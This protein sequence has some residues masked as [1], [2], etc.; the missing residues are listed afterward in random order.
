MKNLF[1]I[2]LVFSI[3]VSCSENSIEH[4]LDDD[5]KIK[6]YFNYTEQYERNYSVKIYNSNDSI[7][8]EGTSII[9]YLDKRLINSKEYFAFTNKLNFNNSHEYFNVMHRFDE[10]YLKLFVDT[11]DSYKLIP[12]SLSETLVLNFVPEL[13]LLKFPIQ[14][15][16][17]W[18]T[19][20][21]DVVIGTFSINIVRFDASYVS[22]ESIQV[23]GY[24]SPIECMK[25]KYHIII[26]LFENE[27]FFTPKIK[28]YDAYIWFGEKVG[29]VKSEGNK[30]FMNSI[31]GKYIDLSDTLYT[32]SL[33]LQ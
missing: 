28:E 16:E 30:F 22:N 9:K 7:I 21:L 11:T 27:D 1:L 6:L 32:E 13:N 14:L 33:T 12:D 19:F 15:G 31:N 25:I 24:N 2:L 4:E 29:I 18:Q 26:T 3:F 23:S 20:S 10:N 8:E 17:S 5:S